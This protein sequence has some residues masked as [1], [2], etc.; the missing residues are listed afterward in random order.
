MVTQA[1]QMAL[2]RAVDVALSPLL[3]PESWPQLTAALPVAGRAAH[4]QRA[5]HHNP[6]DCVPH[7]VTTPHPELLSSGPQAGLS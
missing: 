5:H 6:L 2:E 1:A 4:Y 3:E 7:S